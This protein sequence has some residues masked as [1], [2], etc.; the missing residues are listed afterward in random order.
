MA[1]IVPSPGSAI[2]AIRLTV[3]VFVEAFV[4]AVLQV[5]LQQAR[6]RLAGFPKTD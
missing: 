2:L 3:T 5:A 1:R 4:D 6:S